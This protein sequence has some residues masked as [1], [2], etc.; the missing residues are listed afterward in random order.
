MKEWGKGK[1]TTILLALLSQVKV[2]GLAGA[3]TEFLFKGTAGLTIPACLFR[4][5]KNINDVDARQYQKQS[6]ELE[7]IQN[8]PGFLI[9]LVRPGPKTPHGTQP[10]HVE[11]HP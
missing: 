6:A 7:L 5:P 4:H 11:T 8:I 10:H 2:V 3:S 1:A 9:L